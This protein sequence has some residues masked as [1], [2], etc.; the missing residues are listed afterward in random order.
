MITLRSITC[1]QKN[2][3][4]LVLGDFDYLGTKKTLWYEYPVCHSNHLSFDLGDAF[5]VALIT[6]AM[7]RKVT[8][9]SEVPIS[10]KLAETLDDYQKVI[11]QL[12]PSMYHV[13][14][15]LEELVT[16]TPTQENRICGTGFTAG[17]DAF[18]TLINYYYE[19][20]DS[21]L[22][23]E[24]LVSRNV[25]SFS[26]DEIGNR[27]YRVKRQFLTRVAQGIGLPI[28]FINSNMDELHSRHRGTLGARVTSCIHNLSG[29]YHTFINQTSIN[30][31]SKIA[32]K[33]GLLPQADFLLSSDRVSIVSDG[34]KLTRSSKI[35]RIVDYEIVQKYLNVCNKPISGWNNCSE[36]NKCVSTMLIIDILGKA[37][38]FSDAFD[39]TRFADKKAQYVINN[40]KNPGAHLNSSWNDIK[41]FAAAHDYPLTESPTTK[42]V[43]T[44]SKLTNRETYPAS[45]PNTP[46]E[47]DKSFNCLLLNEL[48]I[49]TKLLDQEDSSIV[50]GGS[51]LSKI[52][53]DFTGSIIGAGFLHEDDAIP[54]S[55]PRIKALRG[56][57]S[58]E[59]LQA[60]SSI[61]LAD[62]NLLVKDLMKCRPDPSWQ[63]AL[64]PS[65][66]E[67]TSPQLHAFASRYA[68]EVVLINMRAKPEKILNLIADS[69]HVISSTLVGLVVA[70]AL[71]IPNRWVSFQQ[72]PIDTFVFDDYY[73]A[74]DIQIS[75][76]PIIGRE[77]LTELLEQT[78]APPT[79]VKEKQS[80]L[81]ALL[82]EEVRPLL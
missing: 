52:P 15:Q 48:G 1:E 81:R 59:K 35:E 65:L 42:A 16:S 70:D 7:H 11:S 76:L 31:H 55:N 5:I 56:K 10:K 54:F 60:P 51:D 72:Q 41:H 19:R 9:R 14:L 40:V 49:S 26:N 69:H 67:Q 2:D 45:Q 82:S 6:E 32:D 17:V 62:S 61:L 46:K 57:L 64:V 22:K 12:Y 27:H 63:L 77:S 68:S 13:E 78:S 75:A 71:G 47:L 33:D 30:F 4:L 18:A 29:L 36:C 25:G 79:S 3:S 53:A 23:V 44:D 58:S 34:A 80:A 38:L 66:P 20:S 24:H 50:L 8:L 73:S 39:F 21:P 37:N 43:V 74:Y 28:T